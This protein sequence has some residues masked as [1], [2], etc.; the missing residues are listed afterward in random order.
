MVRRQYMCMGVIWRF[1]E[2]PKEP[3]NLVAHCA[4]CNRELALV[5]SDR[6]PEELLFG[7]PEGDFLRV[8]S[9]QAEFDAY[10]GQVK[11]EIADNF[12]LK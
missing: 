9:N 8:F 5:S 4:H 6:S 10:L 3:A 12:S 1:D 2:A 7:C 11:Q